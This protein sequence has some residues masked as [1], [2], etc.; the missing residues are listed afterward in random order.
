MAHWKRKGF[1]LHELR[2]FYHESFTC[3]WI[4]IRFEVDSFLLKSRARVHR[5]TTRQNEVQDEWDEFVLML[6]DPTAHILFDKLKQMIWF[7]RF[8]WS[9]A[10][11]E[12]ILYHNPSKALKAN[13]G[14]SEDIN[15]KL[16]M[17]SFEMQT[18]QAEQH[19]P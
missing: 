8:F 15:L 1:F 18:Y 7:Q 11:E 9:N 13:R 12:T 16:L 3:V 6:Q 14:E 2:V 5:L 4:A 10:D 17:E 19:I